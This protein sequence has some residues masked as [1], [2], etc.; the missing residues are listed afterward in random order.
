MNDL[1]FA[2][3]RLATKLHK[4]PN[5]KEAM[6]QLTELAQNIIPA[7]TVERF[8][9]EGVV[10]EATRRLIRKKDHSGL[11]AKTLADIVILIDRFAAANRIDLATAIRERFDPGEEHTT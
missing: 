6:A 5:V 8:V 9:D 7:Q 11:L 3:L 10:D 4:L 1:T 2:E